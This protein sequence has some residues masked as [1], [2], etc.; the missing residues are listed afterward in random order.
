MCRRT[1]C[2]VMVFFGIV[3]VFPISSIASQDVQDRFF[4]LQESDPELF[5]LILA[6]IKKPDVP[7]GFELRTNSP[8]LD[9][10][11]RYNQGFNSC[12]VDIGVSVT[13]LAG[14]LDNRSA[15]VQ[16]ECAIDL[17]TKSKDSYTHS[18]VTETHTEDIY[19]YSSG[20]TLEN[21]E[22]EFFFTSFS[23]IISAKV[24]DAKCEIESIY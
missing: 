11:D 5:R 16:V 13:N 21:I 18:T 10:T 7:G 14:Y 15:T 22:L 12:I 9:C 4:A 24:T 1:V 20:D 6:L 3:C 8:K 23:P 2:K 17:E 19:V